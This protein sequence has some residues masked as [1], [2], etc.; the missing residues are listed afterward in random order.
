MNWGLR[1]ALVVIFLLALVLAFPLRDVVYQF[2]V[3]PLA[4][5]IWALGLFYLSYPRIII[6][7]IFMG[8]V[9]LILLIN[10]SSGWRRS[11]AAKQPEPKHV[12]PVEQLSVLLKKTKR[13]V[14]YRWRVA[15]RISRLARDLLAQREGL[16]AQEVQQRK[17][18]GRDW[19]P[20]PQVEQYFHA[21]L[22]NSFA[23][24][25]SPRW[26]F[27]RPEPTPLDLEVEDAVAFLESQFND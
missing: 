17:M 21:G 8:I 27:Q 22:Y 3:L 6:W 11:K 5:V 19:Y 9:L 14:Y 15:N 12:G 24:Y 10:L 16:E 26:S 4:Y 25:S 20:P 23:S 7:A 13:G 18:T 2:V 1:W